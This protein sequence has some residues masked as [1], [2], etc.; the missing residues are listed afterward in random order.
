MSDTTALHFCSED[1]GGTSQHD[2]STPRLYLENIAAS[3]DRLFAIRKYS[4][5]G[6]KAGVI[7]V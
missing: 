7:A 2:G 4:W 5:Q 6:S 3:Q 1:A